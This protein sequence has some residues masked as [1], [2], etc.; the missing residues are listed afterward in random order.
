VL[1]GWGDA[2]ADVKLARS[3]A[4]EVLKM[5]DA[6]LAPDPVPVLYA[7]LESYLTQDAAAPLTREDWRNSVAG[8][9]RLLTAFHDKVYAGTLTN[10]YAATLY[11]QVIQPVLLMAQGLEQAGDDQVAFDTFYAAVGRLLWD[12]RDAAWPVV[13]KN[14]NKAVEDL[15]SRAIAACEKK[16]AAADPK[17]LAAEYHVRRGW[18]RVEASKSDLTPV[19]DDADKAMKIAA[20]AKADSFDVHGLLAHA[21]LLRS[22]TQAL[23]ADRLK[24]LDV[25]VESGK[26]A[27]KC[28]PKDRSLPTYL[29]DLSCAY[30][31]RAN[32]SY[33]G[34]GDRGREDLKA[35]VEHAKAAAEL[36]KESPDFPYLALGNAYEDLAWIVREE[37]EKNY[38]KAIEAFK[39][40]SNQTLLSGI[41]SCSLARCYY[42]M[43]VD[44][45][46]D[47]LVLNDPKL[48]TKEKVL[49]ECER[50][51]KE[52]VDLKSDLVEAACYLGF[53][54]Q[55]RERYA[56]ADQWFSAA[57]DQAAKQ[58][59]LDCVVYAELWARFPLA[60]EGLQTPDQRYQQT[61]DRAAQIEKMDMPPA[62]A[63]GQKRAVA[64]IRGEV[65]QKKK[66]FAEA[67]AAY[68]EGLPKDIKDAQGHDVPLLLARARANLQLLKSQLNPATFEAVIRDGTRAAALAVT[69]RDKATAQ[70]SVA[71]AHCAAYCQNGDADLDP[72][73]ATLS[74]AVSLSPS[75]PAGLEFRKDAVKMLMAAV[76]SPRGEKTPK[77]I[78]EKQRLLAMIVPWQSEVVAMSEDPSEKS[79]NKATLD[80]I[81]TLLAKVSVDGVDY[82]MKKAQDTQ[83]DATVALSD[84]EKRLLQQCVPWQKKRLDSAQP[85]AKE[86]E[87]NRLGWLE[88]LQGKAK[89]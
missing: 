19:F 64:G 37:P 29:I 67:V 43:V 31:E 85:Q 51:L 4:A 50:L 53:V 82:L 81:E 24:D 73:V 34:G 26:A 30:L 78:S 36:A 68:N 44:G 8:C 58:K 20:T 49:V 46:V 63:A 71:G 59:S 41:A 57:K 25:A 42:K 1:A 40:A 6:D 14:T 75:G 2:K 23:D 22:R 89:P 70:L 56:E 28:P 39:N 62:L 69:P 84:D 72:F 7:C 10:E 61:L 55:A 11:N 21:Y 66:Q 9:T 54:Q 12:N 35:A 88:H 86:D 5:T 87:K 52:A 65:F 18:V 60:N 77:A 16:G 48:D 38:A 79:R 76:M 74:D 33:S 80:G 15:Y 45:G 32:Y 27:V 3:T 13:D 83:Q 17:G 47:P